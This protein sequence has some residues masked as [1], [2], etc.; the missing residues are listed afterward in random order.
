MQ[1]N[2]HHSDRTSLT[3]STFTKD[4]HP[5]ASYTTTTDPTEQFS[6][7]CLFLEAQF[8]DDIVPITTVREH[9]H[10]K[11]HASANVKAAEPRQNVFA[12]GK[13][14]KGD[15][16]SKDKQKTDSTSDSE[17][18]EDAE[19][20]SDEDENE[21]RSAK[22][23][24]KSDSNGEGP[25]EKSATDGNAT[26]KLQTNKISTHDNKDSTPTLK[27]PLTGLKIAIDA[28]GGKQHMAVVW[29]EDL[30][31]EC[32]NAVLRDRVRAVV[33]RALEVLTP[34]SR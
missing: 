16:E 15:E 6:R 5:N 26:T 2:D 27:S 30:S 29:L 32:S 19:S 33:E 31:V 12:D 11:E 21:E 14:A 22:G 4:P 9:Y 34:L 17:S 23:V 7:L 1:I 3:G 13:S 24:V 25:A 10:D 20:E 18:D 28:G 8:G